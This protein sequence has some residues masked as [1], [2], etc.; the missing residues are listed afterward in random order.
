M[1]LCTC[2]V[3]KYFKK[4]LNPCLILTHLH[5]ELPGLEVK[6]VQPKLSFVT[7]KA[8]SVFAFTEF[9]AFVDDGDMRE[10]SLHV[11]I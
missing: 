6:Q 3:L 9:L 5:K 7:I 4:Y 2:D 1:D 11:C 10:Y 8:S